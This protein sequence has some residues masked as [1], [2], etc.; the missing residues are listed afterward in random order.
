VIDG[1]IEA[2]AGFGV[3]EAVESVGL[4]GIVVGCLMCFPDVQA[5]RAAV[6]APEDGM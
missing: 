6:P 5:A 3:E 1:Y 4:H 2:A